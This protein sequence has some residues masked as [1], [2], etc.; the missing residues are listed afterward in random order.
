LWNLDASPPGTTQGRSAGARGIQELVDGGGDPL[1]VVLGDK[2]P[3]A[4]NGSQLGAQ[5]PRQPL[6]VR[7]LLEPVGSTP[8]HRAGT[9]S[10]RSRS[11][12]ARVSAVRS[13]RTCQA[14]AAAP[15]WRWQGSRW[16]AS[17]S[18][19]IA[20]SS[21]PRASIDPTSALNAGIGRRAVTGP[22]ARSARTLG[23]GQES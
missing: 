17:D 5:V 3:A 4:L 13:Q 23:I 21:W 22:A 1:G 7:Q 16:K 11:A 8:H 2:V 20:G 18:R 14:S 10:S 12:T 15:P 19:A 6:A 9:R